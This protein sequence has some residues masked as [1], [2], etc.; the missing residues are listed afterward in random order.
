MIIKPFL[1]RE[2]VTLLVKQELL[3]LYLVP[4]ISGRWL[5]S[6]L[7]YSVTISVPVKIIEK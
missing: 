2:N 3:P 6:D 7:T 4:K 1:S 5:S